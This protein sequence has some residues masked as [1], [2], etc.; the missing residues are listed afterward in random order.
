VTGGA[1][2]PSTSA[3][4]NRGQES[5]RDGRGARSAHDGGKRAT[6]NGAHGSSKAEWHPRSGRDARSGNRKV[7]WW[8]AGSRRDKMV[9][10]F[11]LERLEV[12]VSG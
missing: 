9:F 1:S 8:R 5:A 3:C 7:I 4:D 10:F 6:P 12:R 2:T 11:F